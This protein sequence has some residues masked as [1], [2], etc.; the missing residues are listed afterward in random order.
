M[1]RD[2]RLYIDGDYFSD[3]I[4]ER[5]APFSGVFS[6]EE[7]TDFPSCRYRFWNLGEIV[8]AVCAGGLAIT[9]LTENPHPE[10][11]ILPGTFTLVASR[12]S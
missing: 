4:E 12:A 5:K 3:G 11:P 8:S 9:T 6:S 7:A 10:H 1:D 2:G